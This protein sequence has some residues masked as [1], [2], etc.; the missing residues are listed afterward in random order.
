MGKGKDWKRDEIARIFQNAKLTLL[1]PLGDPK[2]RRTKWNAE[3]Q[4]CGQVIN[5]SFD[6][7]LSTGTDIGCQKCS[8]KAKGERGRTDKTKAVEFLKSL[9]LN[10]L[11]DYPG[12][13]KHWSSQCIH[14]EREVSRSYSALKDAVKKWGIKI[15]CPYCNGNRIIET[16]MQ[17]ILDK[18][19]LIPKEAYTNNESPRLFECAKCGAETR[20]SYINIRRKLR[21]GALSYG[22]PTCS[23]NESGRRR[24]E[25]EENAIVKFQQVGLRMIG[26]YENAR[27]S[28]EC[29]CLR[30]GAITR[31]TLNGV[32]N[33]KTCKF[34]AQR[35]IQHG[36]PAYL[37]LVQNQLH[38]SLKV[39]IGNIG[40]KNDR[41]KS[42]YKQ[43]WELVY[44]WDFETGLQAESIET[45]VFRWL[46][47]DLNLPMHL[48]KNEMPQGGW[49]ETISADAIPLTTLIDEIRSIIDGLLLNKTQM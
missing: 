5:R 8:A 44:R 17:E 1:E 6:S 35:G 46:R 22:C 9:G 12:S 3:C 21:Q 30:C 41:L 10:P 23:F 11:T 48:S 4:I 37:Y 33:G 18:F 7:L 34:C 20:Q 45:M 31:Q 27:K 38:N 40:N 19:G 39:G 43:G 47:N 42:H 36:E 2:Q 26:K 15:G 28:I 49:S 32:N 25:S 13:Q 14:C 24:A 16:D 29:E